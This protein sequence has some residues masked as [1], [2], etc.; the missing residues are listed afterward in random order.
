MGLA[1]GLA[2]HNHARLLSLILA[3]QP[4]SWSAMPKG[5][6]LRLVLKEMMPASRELQTAAELMS[7]IPL[8]TKAVYYFGRLPTSDQV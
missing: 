4:P 7:T 2:T 6:G 8:G 5:R 1:H 3:M